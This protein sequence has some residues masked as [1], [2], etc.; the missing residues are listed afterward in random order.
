MRSKSKCVCHVTFAVQ[1]VSQAYFVVEQEH[2]INF[3]RVLDAYVTFTIN[4]KLEIKI[5]PS[6]ILK[7]S[8]PSTW[9]GN[10]VQGPSRPLQL[11]KVALKGCSPVLKILPC[12]D[13]RSGGRTLPRLSMKA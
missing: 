9:L 5:R 2:N 11:V 7:I 4:D 12:Y 3:E 13:L 10:K 6:T 8:E 1:L